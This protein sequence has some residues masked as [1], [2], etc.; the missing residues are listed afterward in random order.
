MEIAILIPCH[1]EEKTIA[2]VIKDFKAELPFAKIYVCDNNSID[3]TSLEAMTAGAEV[4][5]ESRQGKGY[6]MRKLLKEVKADIYV[7]VDGDDTYPASRIHNLLTPV[8]HKEAEMTLGTRLN[9]QSHFKWLNKIGNKIF[10]VLF[11]LLF[12]RKISDLLTGYRAFSDELARSLPIFSNGFEIE[13]ELTAKCI[14]RNYRIIE[15][16]VA[17]KARPEGSKSKIKIVRDGLLITKTIFCLFRDYKP[18]TFF[19]FIGAVLACLGVALGSIVV[20]EFINT[21]YILRVPSA[22]LSV[23]LVLSGLIA[24]A[25]GL[26]LHTTVRK[27]Q[28]IEW[29]LRNVHRQTPQ[30]TT[31]LSCQKPKII[32]SGS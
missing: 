21:G 3:N 22:I 6:A 14:E 4:L 29:Q 27:F 25:V 16:P 8:W 10:L 5:F 26:I 32:I 12:K 11:N 19:G 28:E 31:C 1:N 18:L 24:S 2:K 15:V 17:L 13:T 30:S 20:N 23:G 9:G 7:M